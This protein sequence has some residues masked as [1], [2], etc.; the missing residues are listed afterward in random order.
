MKKIV[1]VILRGYQL[2]ISPFLG[3]NCR[4]Y[5]SC[6]EYS[7]EA[8]DKHG[9]IKGSYLTVRR[10]LK[11]H[12]WHSGGCDPVPPHNTD[13]KAKTEIDSPIYGYGEKPQENSLKGQKNH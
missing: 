7:M 4:F 13:T 1:L 11:C 8:I 10:L 9:L 6:S 2:L 3:N 5:P 12:P